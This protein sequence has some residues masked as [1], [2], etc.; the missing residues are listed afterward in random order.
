MPI[1]VSFAMEQALFRS[2]I[3]MCKNVKKTGLKTSV[4]RPENLFK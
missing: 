2:R 3:R 1:V 4:N